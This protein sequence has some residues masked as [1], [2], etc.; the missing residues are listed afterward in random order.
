MN[1]KRRQLTNLPKK[2]PELTIVER[3]GRLTPFVLSYFERLFSKPGGSSFVVIDPDAE[4]KS[5][6]TKDLIVVINS[7]PARIYGLRRERA[8]MDQEVLCDELVR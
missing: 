7:L 6:L 8:C 3:K 2:L 5:N 4:E 1:D